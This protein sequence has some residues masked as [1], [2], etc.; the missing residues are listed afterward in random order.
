MPLIPLATV[1]KHLRVDHD[2]DDEIIA[3]YQL[4][5]ENIVT[6]YVDRPLYEPGSTPPLPDESGYDATALIVPPSAVAA[7]LL[8][9]GDMYEIREPDAK[10]AGDA[11]LPRSVRALL[12]PW[13]IWRN[14]D[15]ANV[16]AQT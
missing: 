12:A 8:L 16:T 13:R 3:V 7:I 10:L 15:C 6:E 1:K 4:A 5:A 9:I 2:D 11:V 14:V